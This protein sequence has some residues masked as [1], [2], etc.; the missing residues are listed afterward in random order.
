MV[1]GGTGENVYKSSDPSQSGEHQKKHS[2]RR[3]PLV[4]TQT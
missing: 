1:C 2:H 4:C 3:N